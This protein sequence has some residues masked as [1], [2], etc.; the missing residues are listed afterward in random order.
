MCHE[1]GIETGYNGQSDRGACI[2]EEIV[3][4]ALKGHVSKAGPNPHG[5]LPLPANMPF[6]R[7]GRVSLQKQPE[8]YDDS[9]RLG[10]TVM[11]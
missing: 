4:H 10:V 1:M 2:A 9:Y 6:G 7:L 11:R 8:V 5:E 3:G